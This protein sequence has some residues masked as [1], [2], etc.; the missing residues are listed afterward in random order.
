LDEEDMLPIPIGQAEVL[1]T[2]DDL[3]ILAIGHGVSEAQQAIEL[4]AA[5]NIYPTIVNCRFVKPLDAELIIRLARKIPRIITVEDHVLHGGFGSAILE[6]LADH[7]IKGCRIRR[8]GIQDIFVEHGPSKILR[9][10]YGID[11]AAVVRA[12]ESLISESDRNTG[13]GGLA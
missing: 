6:C 9:G 11:A 5:K 3:L 10:K 8:I 4:L 12:A 2:G 7:E 1:E 13:H